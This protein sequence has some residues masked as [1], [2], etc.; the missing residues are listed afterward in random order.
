MSRPSLSE[1]IAA[2]R[3]F[4]RSGTAGSR[5]ELREVLRRCGQPAW[6]I[7]YEIDRIGI[8]RYRSLEYWGRGERNPN[9]LFPYR[10]SDLGGP[11]RED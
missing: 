9:S 4:L 10:D 6:V 7:A 8:A 11:A 3:G 2:V 5:E 1:Q